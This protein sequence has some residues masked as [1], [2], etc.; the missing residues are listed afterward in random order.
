MNDPIPIFIATLHLTK[1]PFAHISWIK[2]QSRGWYGPSSPPFLPCCWNYYFYMNIILLSVHLAGP[3][4][5]GAPNHHH[6]LSSWSFVLPHLN[7]TSTTF[8]TPLPL[9]PHPHY[10]PFPLYPSTLPPANL[11]PP[12]TITP[13]ITFTS[14]SSLPI[15]RSKHTTHL[16]PY[17]FF[18]SIQT[19]HI[20]LISKSQYSLSHIHKLLTPS[21]FATLSTFHIYRVFQLP[22]SLNHPIITL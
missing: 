15:L 7:F 18:S 3:H 22:N 8:P 20:H 16:F 6:F 4:Y 10:T 14:S 21:H 9:T 5:R 12:Q 11:S 17:R 2:M 1:S 19:P 13:H